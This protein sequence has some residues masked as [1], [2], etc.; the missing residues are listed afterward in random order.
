MKIFAYRKKICVVSNFWGM[1]PTSANTKKIRVQGLPTLPP[2]TLTTA[3]ICIH[4]HVHRKP[5]ANSHINTRVH[6]HTYNIHIYRSARL[7]FMVSDIVLGEERS[8]AK[9]APPAIGA[10]TSG[11]LGLRELGF[12]V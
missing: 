11:G 8:L 12:R 6:L 10:P 5:I 3:H 7:P 1:I 4:T 2:E 9:R